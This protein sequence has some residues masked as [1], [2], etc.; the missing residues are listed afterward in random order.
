MAGWSTGATG[1]LNGDGVV[2]L[3]NLHPEQRLVD[4]L[5]GE[6]YLFWGDQLPEEL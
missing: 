4:S 6:V 2:D 5:K 1:D 3:Y